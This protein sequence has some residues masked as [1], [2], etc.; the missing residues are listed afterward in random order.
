MK[1]VMTIMTTILAVLIIVMR[2]II[3]NHRG[4]GSIDK[5]GVVV[6]LEPHPSRLG[7]A[8]HPR[9]RPCELFA[10][11]IA[12]QKRSNPLH[13]PFA[14]G[15]VNRVHMLQVFEVVKANCVRLYCL[16]SRLSGSALITHTVCSQLCK[17][18]CGWVLAKG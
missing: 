14:T 8:T 17:Y 4:H 12:V 15:N 2:A 6:E 3:I 13:D 11:K 9:R 18:R 16:H 5:I 1:I 7:Q 10:H